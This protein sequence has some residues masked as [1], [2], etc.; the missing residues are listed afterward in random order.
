MD[1]VTYKY[2]RLCR[3][4]VADTIAHKR[5]HTGCRHSVDKCLCN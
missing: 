3:A 4:I 5:V 1:K 2:C